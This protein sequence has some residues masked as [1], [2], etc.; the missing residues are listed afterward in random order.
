M[1]ERIRAFLSLKEN[2]KFFIQSIDGI[3]YKK[4]ELIVFVSIII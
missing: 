3:A 4:T 2:G 1:R